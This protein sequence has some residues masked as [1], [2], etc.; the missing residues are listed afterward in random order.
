[1]RLAVGY[2]AN[3]KLTSIRSNRKRKK[4][5]KGEREGKSALLNSDTLPYIKLC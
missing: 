4:R 2:F 1:M 5:K 3:I